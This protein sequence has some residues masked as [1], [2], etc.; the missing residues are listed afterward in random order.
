MSKL[1]IQEKTKSDYWGIIGSTLC[2][3]HCAF[4]PFIITALSTV[5]TAEDS[6][7]WLDYVFI[8]LC[9]WAVFHSTK[10]SSSKK[11]KTGLWAAWS[12][13]AVGIVFEDAFESMNY[14]AYAGSAAL[15]ILHILNIRHFKHCEKCGH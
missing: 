8:T 4:T 9:F 3:V 6:L 5:K 15:V 7:A 14:I 1:F 13:F 2:A 11:I 12:V 10:H